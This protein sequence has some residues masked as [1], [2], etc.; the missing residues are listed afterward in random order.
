VSDDLKETILPGI[1]GVFQLR[2]WSEANYLRN[3]VN[4]NVRMML[5]TM[6]VV[7]GK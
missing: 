7:I 3:K 5:M 2:F 4:N 6:E 1:G